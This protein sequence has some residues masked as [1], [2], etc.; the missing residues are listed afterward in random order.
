MKTF[1]AVTRNEMR[2][3]WRR[4]SFWILQA[5]LLLPAVVII[6]VSLFDSRNT[7]FLYGQGIPGLGLAP[8]LYLVMPILAG[9]SILRDLKST[10]ELLWSSPLDPLVYQTGIFTGLWLG[11]L[12]VTLLQ[13]GSW[14]L[15]G[16]FVPVPPPLSAWSYTLGLYLLTNTLGISLVFLAAMLTRRMLPLLLGWTALWGIVFFKVEFMA[17]FL[18]EGYSPMATLAFWN[19]F[20]HNLA[21]SPTLRL[22]LS[23]RLVLSMLVW[24]LGLALA[25]FALAGLLGWLFDRRRT[26]HNLV[27]WGAL[28]AA[29]LVLLAGGYALNAAAVAAATP[30]VSPLDPQIDSWQVVEQTTRVE[31]NAR[32]GELSGTAT[33]HLEPDEDLEEP[34]LVLRLNPGLEVTRAIAGGNEPLT[35]ERQGDSVIFALPAPAEGALWLEVDWEGELQISLL[36]YDLPW[37]WAGAP[38]DYS[39]KYAPLPVRGLI[40]PQVGYLLRDG[41]WMPWPWVTTP[42]Q[43][44]VGRVSI[45]LNGARAIAPAPLRDGEVALEAPLPEALLVYHDAAPAAAGNMRIIATPWLNAPAR[46]QV[47]LFV[48][49]VQ[50]ASEMLGETPPGTLVVLPYLDR[51]IWA[52]DLLLLPDDSGKYISYHLSWMQGLYWEQ[53]RLP[54]VENPAGL[55]RTTLAALLRQWMLDCGP[56]P[57]LEYHPLMMGSDEWWNPVTLG[58]VTRE[59]WDEQGGRWAQHPEAQVF[60]TWWAP[61]RNTALEPV[62]KLSALAFWLATETSYPDLFLDDLA[63]AEKLDAPGAKIGGNETYRLASARS[64]PDVMYSDAG[65]AEVQALHEWALEVGQPRANELV[66]AALLQNQ[67]LAAEELWQ[68]LATESGVA[69]M[70]VQ[71]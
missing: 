18:D 22:G 41:D 16:I 13:L 44:L 54:G 63:L 39:Y 62:G 17:A 67:P 68:I 21:L 38:G 19:V 2:V 5:V 52:G 29:G 32:N 3:L 9:P 34:R 8:L 46:Q 27:A 49:A 6:V 57:E 65:R 59:N 64:W 43:A 1:W 70:G 36:S 31:V 30:P 15:A 53:D 24:F 56:A 61:R 25:A 60:S 37:K 40:S 69:L 50:Q 7:Q 42:H 48:S 20:F 12:P 33:L 11:L 71:P 47:Y 66:I 35:W 26:L 23:Q 10:G 51:I 58:A 4:R 55:E 28:S 45:A 14:R